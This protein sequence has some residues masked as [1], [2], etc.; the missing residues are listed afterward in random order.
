MH[1]YNHTLKHYARRLRTN[2]TDSEQ[3]LWA[4]LRSKNLL[5][6]QFYRQKPLGNY[7]VDFY[8]PRAGLVIEID[9]SQHLEGEHAAKDTQRDAYLVRQGL[10]VLRFSNMQVLQ[11]LDEVVEIIY[12]VMA[13]RIAGRQ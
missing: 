2:M 9:G 1:P 3:R 10:Q 8:A 4:R 11:A 13:A 12:R 5:G 7:I 6:V